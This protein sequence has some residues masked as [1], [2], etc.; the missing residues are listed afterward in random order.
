MIKTAR[1]WVSHVSMKHN[2]A[3]YAVYITRPGHQQCAEDVRPRI[4]SK[5]M[6]KE[7]KQGRSAL[8]GYWQGIHDKFLEAR[9]TPGTPV[10]HNAKITARQF[11]INL[12]NDI[13]DAQVN[14]LAKAVLRDFPR[15]LPVSLVLHRESNRGKPHMHLQGLFSYRNGGYGSINDDF[16]LNITGQM[17]QTVAREFE[18]FG[19]RRSCHGIRGAVHETDLPS[20]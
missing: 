14:Q 12:P 17:K 2:P 10:H 19:Y 13:D 1:L 20:A 11:V 5:S 8:V 9:R 15:H 16:R 3:D 6:P 7:C 18:R 4:W